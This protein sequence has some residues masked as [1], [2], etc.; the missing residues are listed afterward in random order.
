[1]RPFP[2][3]EID[4]QSP[5][6]RLFRALRHR[7]YRL[8]FAA[9]V[10]N[11]MGFWLANLAMQGVMVELTD[12]DPAWIGRLFFAFFSPA[13]LLA[14]VA[15]VVAD[16]LD[17]QWIMVVCYGGV[18]LTSTAL[19]AMAAG[20]LLTPARLMSLA[21]LC[22][23]SLCFLGP[24]ASAVAANVVEADDLA[25]AVSLQSTANNLTRVVGPSLAAPLVAA[26]R[27]GTSFAVFAATSI[28]AA[29]L[30]WVI[31]VPEY[32]RDA[33]AARVW[34]RIRTGLRHVRER[35]PAG[36][37]LLTASV[38]SVFGVSH[39]A[40]LPSFAEQVLGDR[41]V[42][43]WIFASTGVGAMVGAVV[44]GVE[45]APILRRSTLRL[46][47]YGLVLVGFASSRSLAWAL[48]AQ[49]MVGF[50]YFSIM[51]SLQT[52]LQEVVDEAKRG[53]VMALFHVAW[54]GLFPIG[55]L[56]LGEIAKHLGVSQAITAA[57]VFC[58]AVGA[59]LTLRLRAS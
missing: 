40:L 34:E 56:A 35:Y 43:P 57:G 46:C 8:F 29:A 25:S 12:N 21:F 38:L 13:L 45:G 58:A 16:R 37:A 55:A 18:A 39:T 54:G 7:G 5:L 3:V 51:T 20:D 4:P 50:F 15:G 53:R 19:G 1:M 26:G 14:P 11:Q 17:R 47:L 36:L 59:V 28:V 52:L 10:C 31:Q 48:V 44:T 24:A 22:G 41:D 42:F 32:Q 27:Y 9:F 30:V 49:A 33:G 2:P 6:T 23:L